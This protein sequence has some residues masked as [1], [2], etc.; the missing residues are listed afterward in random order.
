LDWVAVTKPPTVRSSLETA[1]NS[2]SWNSSPSIQQVLKHAC[3]TCLLV[4]FSLPTSNLAQITCELSLGDTTALLAG[5]VCKG[6]LGIV[7]AKLASA[8]TLTVSL[9]LHFQLVEPSCF[10]RDA[11]FPCLSIPLVRSFVDGV[12][13]RDPLPWEYRM[14]RL[15]REIC[16]PYCQ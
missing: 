7:L 8:F 12:D 11:L 13:L 9:S 10:K 14:Q 6:L 16:Q 2:W 1:R 3:L 5:K 4:N 15:Y